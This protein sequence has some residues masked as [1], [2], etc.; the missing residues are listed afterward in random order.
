MANVNVDLKQTVKRIY[1]KIMQKNVKKVAN[2]DP[3][4]R[5]FRHPIRE[6]RVSIWQYQLRQ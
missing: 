5:P 6:T 4:V 2:R 1:A 3:N